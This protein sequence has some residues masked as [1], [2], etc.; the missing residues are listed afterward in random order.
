MDKRSLAPMYQHVAHSQTKEGVGLSELMGH[1][2]QDKLRKKRKVH[3][4]S[5]FW[6][7]N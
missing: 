2:L 5:R 4:H 6:E 3:G 7:K 1:S